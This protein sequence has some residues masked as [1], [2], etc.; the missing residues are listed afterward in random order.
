[1]SSLWAYT[2]GHIRFHKKAIHKVFA[3][4]GK[5]LSKFARLGIRV[6]YM[7]K[8]HLAE[9]VRIEQSARL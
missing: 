8:K 2:R 5:N 7:T 3:K 9:F 4:S 1:M 6:G